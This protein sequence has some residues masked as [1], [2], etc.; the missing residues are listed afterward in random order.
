MSDLSEGK[1]NEL[2]RSAIIRARM[3]ELCGSILKTAYTTEELFTIGLFS[4]MD[5]MLDSEMGEI[6]ENIAFS[7]K[8]KNALL[9]NDK[10]FEKIALLVKSFEQGDWC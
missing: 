10:D 4:F 5:A 8:I 6:L 9:G 3:V 1:P 2:V 7:E